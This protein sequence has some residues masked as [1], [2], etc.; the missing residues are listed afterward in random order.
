[1]LQNAGFFAVA[2]HQ[3]HLRHGGEFGGVDLRGAA[4]NHQPRFGVL[5]AQA[6]NGLTALAFGLAGD[7]AGVDHNQVVKLFE[8]LLQ[9]F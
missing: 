1:M 5:A 4:R 8:L 9:N 3:I 6:A 7:G 2:Q